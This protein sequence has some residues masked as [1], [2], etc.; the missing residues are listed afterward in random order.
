MRWEFAEDPT[1]RELKVV[2]RLQRGSKFYVFLWK[3]RSELFTPEFQDEL[4]A[5]YKPRG[6]API[7]AAQLAMVWLLQAYTGLSDRDA[8]EHALFDLRW[9]LILGTMGSDEAPFGQGSLPRFRARIIEHE[10][11]QL[12]DFGCHAIEHFRVDTEI[13]ITGKGFTTQFQQNP[14]VLA[15][16]C[17]H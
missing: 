15:D 13:S 5:A 10:L 17:C 4:A 8:V 11:D 9:K 2:R 12:A 6:Q 14:V 3:I 7:P 1:E 16:F